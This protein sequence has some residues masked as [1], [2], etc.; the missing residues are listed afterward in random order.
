MWDETM[1]DHTLKRL[2]DLE[3]VLNE[4]TIVVFTDQKGIIKYANDKFCK[5]SEFTKEELIGQPQSIV[6]S[7][8]HNRAFFKNMWQTIGTGNIWHGEIKNKTKSGGYYWVDTYIVPFLNEKGKPYQYVSIRNDITK[9]KE[10]EATIKNLAFK[11]YLTNLPNRT[12]LN[13]WL[14]K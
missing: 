9:L 3:L 6:N 8:Y 11:D 4:T 7:G 2:K 10:Q 12:W 14:K 1:I 13:E 5:L